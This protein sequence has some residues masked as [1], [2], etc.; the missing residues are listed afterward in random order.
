MGVGFF[1]FYI[2]W[3]WVT[4]YMQVSMLVNTMLYVN[5]RYLHM[6]S[7]PSPYP[8]IYQAP[9]LSDWARRRDI[10]F[11]AEDTPSQVAKIPLFGSYYYG[12][13]QPTLTYS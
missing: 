4:E 10:I 2:V 9:M 1:F 11:L 6:F 13:H 7:H 3:A 8:S 5:N 12:R